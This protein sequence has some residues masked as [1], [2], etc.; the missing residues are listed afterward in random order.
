M[1]KA[2]PYF[3]T[4]L[5]IKPFWLQIQAESKVFPQICKKALRPIDKAI[6]IIE[7]EIKLEYEFL[8]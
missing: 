4:Q 7:D 5:I 2:A 8:F 6:M 3:L 1:F